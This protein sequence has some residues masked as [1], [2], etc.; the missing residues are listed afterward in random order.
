MIDDLDVQAVRR[1]LWQLG[2]AAG[3]LALADKLRDRGPAARAQL[4]ARMNEI[5]GT[6]IVRDLLRGAA[7]ELK[8]RW[9]RPLSVADQTLIASALGEAFDSGL[10]PVSFIEQLLWLEENIS[11]PVCNERSAEMIAASGSRELVRAF[12]NRS[13]LFARNS[14]RAGAANLLLGA[15]RAM[16]SDPEV[17]Q[18]HLARMQATGELEAFLALIAPSRRAPTGGYEASDNA[19]ASLVNGAAAIQPPTAEVAAVF[20]FA[21]QNCRQEPGL[22]DALGNLFVAADN[23]TFLVK[24]HPSHAG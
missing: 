3:A 17:L 24:H 10:L 1:R 11:N 15:T 16:A 7:G 6:D 5:E 22:D 18:E 4:L 20:A 9:D 23:P 12:V 2:R 8:T 14:P 13:F 19:L 21:S